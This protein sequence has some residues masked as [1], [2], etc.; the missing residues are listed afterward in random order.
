[1]DTGNTSPAFH[2][3]S[4]S[5][6]AGCVEVAFV[7]ASASGGVGCVTV[8]HDESTAH[9]RNTRFPERC[10]HRSQA[11]WAE[12]VEQAQESR[13][14]ILGDWFPPERFGDFAGTFTEHERICFEDGILKKEPQLVGPGM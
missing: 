4:A 2:T 7:T 10:E 6:G 9:V 11:D 1:M 13:V 14:V 8:G 3:A 5:G 12:L